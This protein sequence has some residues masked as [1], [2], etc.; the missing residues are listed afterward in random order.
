MPTLRH[1]GASPRS[2]HKQSTARAKNSCQRTTPVT[3]KTEP[4]SEKKLDDAKKKG[5]V[6]QSKDLASSFAFFFGLTALV[7]TAAS[8]DNH[9]RKLIETALAMPRL[10]PPEV[11]PALYERLYA[12]ATEGVW[13]VAPVIGAAIIGSIVGGLAHVGVNI[14]F[15]P[16][17]PKFDKIDPVGGVKKLFSLKS[18]FEVFKTVVKAVIIGWVLYVLMRSVAPLTVRATYGSA[19][20]IGITAWASVVRLL[21]VCA[22]LFVILG[23]VDFVVQRLL[24]HKEQKMS[25]DEVKREYKQSEGDPQL[26]GERKAIAQEIAFS[27][28][29]PAV[30]GASAVVVNPT[31]YAVALRYR[32]EERGLPVIVAK[33]VDAEAARI[34][35]IAVENGVPIIGNPELARAL[36]KVNLEADVPEQFFDAVAIVL[37]W[38]EQMRGGEPA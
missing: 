25:K 27:D 5:Q 15:E 31:H 36:F 29:T 20:S 7:V 28:P 24:F 3:E 2:I 9:V 26:K 30:A 10:G 13:V 14:S 35:A 11:M 21:S 17:T 12:L 23:V 33:G 18:L 6:A 4:A 32:P 16:L 34:R 8:S 22:V 1:A 37:R 19:Q 38:A